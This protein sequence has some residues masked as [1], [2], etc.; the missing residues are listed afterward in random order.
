VSDPGTPDAASGTVTLLAPRPVADTVGQL[1]GMVT[2]RGMKVFAVIDQRREAEQAGLE[3]RETT[4]VL[5]GN[6]A[7]GTPVMESAPLSALDLPLKILVWDDRGQTKVSYTDPATLADR[8][9]LS[10]AL[11]QRLAGIRALADALAGTPAGP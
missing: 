3:L 7:G 9:G 8:Y 1:T 10:D 6:P 5:F 11:T 4:L 2:D